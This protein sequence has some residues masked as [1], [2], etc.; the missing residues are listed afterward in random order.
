MLVKGATAGAPRARSRT[1]S[2]NSSPR[3]LHRSS[4]QCLSDLT[5]STITSVAM[6]DAGI[7]YLFGT[8]GPYIWARTQGVISSQNKQCLSNSNTVQPVLDLNI[9]VTMT[10]TSITIRGDT[11]F[12]I[13][14]CGNVFSQSLLKFLSLSNAISANFTS[15]RDCTDSRTFMQLATTTVI[16]VLENNILLVLRSHWALL[17]N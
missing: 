12:D 10:S 3:L 16:N 2:P 6:I 1:I 14:F 17:G 4:R 5:T 11:Y 13:Q 15:I 9:R 7:F 8:V